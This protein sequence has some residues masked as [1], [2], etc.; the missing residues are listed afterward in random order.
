[1]SDRPSR[2]FSSI[3]PKEEKRQTGQERRLVRLQT[4]A[5]TPHEVAA[6]TYTDTGRVCGIQVGYRPA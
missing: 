5:K 4:E 3:K 1:M 2:P 6:E